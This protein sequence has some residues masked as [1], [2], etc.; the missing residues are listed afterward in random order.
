MPPK[1]PRQTKMEALKLV[2]KGFSKT[3]AAQI[4]GI[5]T[6]TIYRA[7]RKHQRTGDIEG[8]REVRG[9]KPKVTNEMKMVCS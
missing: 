4:F 5:S 8:G 6:K 9:P 7:D 2:E 3:D 1:I